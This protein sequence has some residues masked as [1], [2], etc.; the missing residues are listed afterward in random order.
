MPDLP[1]HAELLELAAGLRRMLD[2][3]ARGEVSASS[4]TASRL[5]G[6]WLAIETIA[7]GR[8]LDISTLS[9]T[10]ESG[11]EPI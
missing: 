6:A 3:I 5:E 11:I 4:G 10:G 9:D 2:A 7:N 8:V 1:N